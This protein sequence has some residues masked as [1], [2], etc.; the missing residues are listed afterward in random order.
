[1]CLNGINNV[2]YRISYHMIFFALDYL[3]TQ[4]WEM[5]KNLPMYCIHQHLS[6]CELVQ[7]P[8]VQYVQHI[9]I[10]KKKWFL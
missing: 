1:M 5:Y 10:Y 3:K 6:I 2:K 9:C 7:E 8:S 4:T